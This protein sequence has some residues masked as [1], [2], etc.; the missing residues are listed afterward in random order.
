[1]GSVVH[2]R[3]SLQARIVTGSMVLLSGSGLTTAINL[4]YNIA[5]ARFLGP[6]G[7]A[8][9]TVVYTLLTLLSAVTLSAQIVA[10]KVVAQ[11]SS[12]EGRTAVYRLFHRAS[13]ACGI[14]VAL[15]LVG[16]QHTIADYLNLDDPALVAIIAIGAA[17]YIP[18]GSRRGFI[19]GTC[20]FRSLATNLVSE[21]AARLVGS[22][23]MILLG[24]GVRGVI[25]ANSAAIAIAYFG[26]RVKLTGHL[27][28]PLRLSYAVHET[29]QAVVF[30][31][32]QMI[33]TNSSIVLVNHFFQAREA[34][35]YAV[36]AM[37]GRVML[38][39]S[40]AVVN[41]TFPLVAGTRHEDRRDL[42]VIATSL[43]LVF[44]SGLAVSVA[45]CVA[46]T[47]LWIHLFGQA[48]AA[49]QYNIPGLLAIYALATVIY[50][51]GAVII[52]FEMSY[53]ITSTSWS[54]L[55]F[56]G[57]LI[58]AIIRYHSSLREVI[59]VQLALMMI[60]FAFVAVPFIIS[61]LTDPKEMP[62]GCEPIRLT[63][64]VSEDA[65]I[66]EFL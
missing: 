3:K 26:A 47:S 52:T 16:F 64:R 2:T 40:Q 37:V 17:L 20:G 49:G 36:V 10:S 32:G 21:Q 38:S 50:S 30:F 34:G 45:L 42:S 54:Q 41:S 39:F 12:A 18:L 7:F 33:I 29:C 24:Y 9:A 65:A 46:P 56:S 22:L 48:F 1:M 55:I 5:V 66:A 13:W 15:L 51:L 28:N 44:G 59:L 11:Q 63:R 27:R 43:V 58:F 60:L 4:V 31:A 6:R 57:V 23:A 25:V 62:Q 35:I 61:S 53:K 8:H 19:Q 14:P